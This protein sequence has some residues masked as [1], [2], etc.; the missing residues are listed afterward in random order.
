MERDTLESLSAGILNR[1]YVFITF[2]IVSC[3]NIDVFE[4]GSSQIQ[5]DD[6]FGDS[7]D[8]QASLFN[9]QAAPPSPS[10]SNPVG[11]GA[12]SGLPTI[13]RTPPAV[14]PEPAVAP[15]VQERI[16]TV[17]KQVEVEQPREVHAQPVRV[18]V[19]KSKDLVKRALNHLQ[20]DIGQRFDELTEIIESLKPAEQPQG[21]VLPTDKIM[22]EIEAAVSA[23]EAKDR[24]IRQKQLAIESMSYSIA[25]RE[26]RTT[27]RKDISELM[28]EIA[29]EGARFADAENDFSFKE[30][31]IERLKTELVQAASKNEQA[32]QRLRTQVERDIA[33]AKRDLENERKDSAVRIEQMR[34]E[35]KTMTK[36]TGQLG[37]ENQKLS[38]MIPKTT[39]ADVDSF[40]AQTIEKLKGV[41]RKLVTDVNDMITDNLDTENEY[42]GDVVCNA[43]KQAL[44]R[45][46]EVILDQND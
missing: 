16:K 21:A 14:S 20:R 43:M 23:S 9:G 29:A 36:Q 18:Q 30:Q 1:N 17:Q 15:P 7:N 10:R 24:V 5:M 33:K 41:I 46:A 44:Q 35:V 6:L 13:S 38:K 39:Q 25:E 27:L 45:T 12:A 42:G 34:Q 19:V 3:F 2:L 32:E 40:Q 22:R 28:E 31:E 8:D 4:N 26:E 11:D 37:A